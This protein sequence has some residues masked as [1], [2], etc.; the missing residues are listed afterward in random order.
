MKNDTKDGLMGFLL[1]ALLPL[2]VIFPLTLVWNIFAE[3]FG[4]ANIMSWRLLA[5][6]VGWIFLHQFMKKRFEINFFDAFRSGGI[7]YDG[8]EFLLR[9]W[10]SKE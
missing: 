1:I 5:M 4:Y 10:C 8:I 6:T 9:P 3:I 7:V 2:Y